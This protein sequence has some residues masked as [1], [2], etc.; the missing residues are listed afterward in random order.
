MTCPMTPMRVRKIGCTSDKR[1]AIVV[2]EDVEQRVW[3]AF[4]TDPHEAHR[5]AREMGRAPCTCNP[6]YDFIQLLLDGIQATVSRIVLDD[7]G[8]RGIGATV[9]LWLTRRQEGLTVQC[10]PPD[11]LALALRT[12]APIYATPQVLARAQRLSDRPVLPPAEDFLD[13]LEQ[14]N[15]DDF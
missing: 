11:A 6:V 2:L 13:W 5:L 15:P 9:D 14:V 3:V 10:Y 1:R 8:T 7:A 4:T 12:K